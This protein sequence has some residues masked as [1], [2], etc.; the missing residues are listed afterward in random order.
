MTPGPCLGACV[1]AALQAQI[2]GDPLV[3]KQRRGPSALIPETQTSAKQRQA[4]REMDGNKRSR[5]CKKENR[6]GKGQGRSAVCTCR[7]R[8]CWR[9]DGVKIGGSR[10]A[11]VWE[12]WIARLEEEGTSWENGLGTSRDHPDI[13]RRSPSGLPVSHECFNRAPEQNNRPTVQAH[14]VHITR[15]PGGIGPFATRG[16]CLLEDWGRGSGQHVRPGQLAPD[17]GV[18]TGCPAVTHSSSVLT[19]PPRTKV[20]PGRGK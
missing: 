8:Q 10:A 12:D 9:S 19:E 18:K 20:M 3:A 4:G 2:G 5:L 13:F 7:C 11:G 17:P 15:L 6:R 1:F 16:V 14:R